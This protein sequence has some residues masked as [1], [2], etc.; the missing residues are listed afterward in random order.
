MEDKGLIYGRNPVLEYLNG[1]EP[2][3]PLELYIA[4]HSH[5]KIIDIITGTARTKKIAV[6][7]MDKDFFT[8][9]GP[10]SRHQGVALRLPP[11]ARESAAG[12]GQ[13]LERTAADRGVLV[14]LDQV[15]DP[16]NA[17]SIIRTAEAL[18][19]CGVVIPKSHAAGI[20]PAV[21]KASAGATAHIAIV[22]VSN[23]ASFLEGAK[24]QGFWIIG[25][26]DHGED[27]LPRL[28]EYRPAILV[29]G[30]EGG[31]MR[32]LTE[33][34][35]DLI[36]RIPLKGSVSSLNASVAAGIVLYELLK[37]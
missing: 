24:K 33:E 21:I 28:R 36:A 2:G 11:D 12:S 26:S 6:R 31:G 23:I 30:S 15:T 9:L 17:G 4:E 1:A 25:T 20:T 8:R 16:Q 5:G 35:C 32:R 18:G 29:I 37:N 14:L 34:K 22:T 7:R 27:A 10:S 19:C 13:I 3:S